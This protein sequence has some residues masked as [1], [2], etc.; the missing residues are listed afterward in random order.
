[1]TA[2][3]PPPGRA[4]RLVLLRTLRTAEHGADLLEQKLRILRAEHRRLLRA[5][6][7][8]AED[9]HRLLRDAETWLLRA[10]VLGGRGALD[11]ACD[12][13]PPAEA[14]VP[15]TTTL[16]VP[17]PAGCDCTARP[18]PASAAPPRNAALAPAADAHRA[19]LR[20]AG[21]YAAAR[22]AARAVGAEADATRRRLR[23]LRRR[24]IPELRR[25]LALA[26]LAL[27]QAEHEDA[28]RRRRAAARWPPSGAA[29]RREPW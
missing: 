26:D 28:V 13:V 18:R 10:L 8:A 1:M 27:E 14:R 20:A 24:R 4:G 6:E 16:G 21:R 12:G 17:H 19:A 5:E 22:A 23:A 29:A 9:W 25:D 11:A 2:R 3:R 7:E 15:R